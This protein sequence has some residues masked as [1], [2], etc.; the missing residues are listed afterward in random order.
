MV[1][2]TD[3][4]HCRSTRTHHSADKWMIGTILVLTTNILMRPRLTLSYFYLLLAPDRKLITT[5]NTAI[6][7]ASLF[8]LHFSHHHFQI[9]LIIQQLGPF[10]FYDR[11]LSMVIYYLL[12]IE[13][14]C[15]R[16]PGKLSTPVTTQEPME[17]TTIRQ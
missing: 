16:E 6:R 4:Y 14:T 15:N 11:I 13:S 1:I 9:S 10:D 7:T 8:Y 12:R 2:Y 5:H 3:A 17:R